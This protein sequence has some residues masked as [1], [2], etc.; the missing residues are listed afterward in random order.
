MTT[1][2]PATAALDGGCDCRAIRYRLHARPLFVHC[3]HCRWCQ[4]ETGSA[5]AIN[6][7]I[8]RD[9][10]ELLAGEPELVHTPSASGIGQRIA[11]CPACRLAVW[12][13]YGGAGERIAFV[14]VGTLDDPDACP[15]DIHIFTSTKQ[16]W[17]LLPP[18]VPAVPEY[19]RASERWPAESIARRAAMSPPREA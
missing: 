13:H 16:P 14:R 7:L 11:R 18:D 17:V 19:Y 15:P 8:E 12:S 9:R 3:C 4:R 1:P 6:A 2:D 10:V 5:F